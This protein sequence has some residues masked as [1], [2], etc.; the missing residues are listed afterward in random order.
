MINGVPD[1]LLLDSGELDANATGQIQATVT[2]TFP[3]ADDWFFLTMLSDGTPTITSYSTIITTPSGFTALNSTSGINRYLK[4]TAYGALPASYG[5]PTT[6][7]NLADR[8]G[9]RAV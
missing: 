3:Y 7:S 4:T 9:V 2:F 1:A 8:I 6:E 5:T